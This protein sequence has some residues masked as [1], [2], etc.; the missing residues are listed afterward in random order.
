M[1]FTCEE[2]NM[3]F[4]VLLVICVCYDKSTYLQIYLLSLTHSISKSNK[5]FT[6]I[7][8]RKTITFFNFSH[9]IDYNLDLEVIKDMNY[10][11]LF[12]NAKDCCY[13]LCITIYLVLL[14]FEDNLIV[15][16]S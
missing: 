10:M 14:S 6:I 3:I 13:V 9:F 11:T 5:G 8:K 4:H 15:T 12:M 1:I 7:N 16:V 2:Q